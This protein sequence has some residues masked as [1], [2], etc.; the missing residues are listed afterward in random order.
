MSASLQCTRPTT[1][2]REKANDL[3]RCLKVLH[4]RGFEDPSYWLV[5]M[6]PFLLTQRRFFE[7]LNFIEQFNLLSYK[8]GGDKMF[9]GWLRNNK[10]VDDMDLRAFDAYGKYNVLVLQEPDVKKE[11]KGLDQYD[12]FTSFV[13][14]A[15]SVW[16]RVRTKKK[17]RTSEV[18]KMVHEYCTSLEQVMKKF[19][20]TPAPIMV[21]RVDNRKFECKTFTQVGCLSTAYTKLVFGGQEPNLCI[22]LPQGTPCLYIDRI[23]EDL[24]DFGDRPDHSKKWALPE[25]EVLL[26]HGLEYFTSH[27]DFKEYGRTLLIARIEGFRPH[28][29]KQ[30]VEVL[31]N[32]CT[33][34]VFKKHITNLELSE[35]SVEYLQRHLSG[36]KC[37]RSIL[38]SQLLARHKDHGVDL[39]LFRLFMKQT[40]YSSVH[41]YKPVL[42]LVEETLKEVKHSYTPVLLKEFYRFV[43]SLP[44]KDTYV[45][46]MADK[47]RTYLYRSS[48]QAYFDTLFAGEDSD[49]DNDF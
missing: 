37:V 28:H 8:Y 10:V 25:Y 44:Q 24:F 16:Y 4:E 12:D 20:K 3:L 30:W 41:V 27:R 31:T 14:H 18:Y 13:K 32:S 49:D 43:L 36:N 48:A 29:C 26:P 21:Y 35:S 1:S 17:Y 19:P 34:K 22:F 7:S 46:Q 42:E 33:Y 39:A 47:L 9:N 38:K 40:P 5:H 23:Y 11:L 15:E 6:I 45:K 2:Q